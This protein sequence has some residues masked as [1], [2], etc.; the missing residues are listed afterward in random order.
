MAILI[1]VSPTAPPF[2]LGWPESQ[3]STASPAAPTKLAAHTTT[4]LR[5]TWRV[6]TQP[7]AHAIASRLLPVKSSAP[8][9]VT[10]IRPSENARPP[11]Q[12]R[13]GEAERRVA[14]DQREHQR[15]QA[16]ECS[17]EHAEQGHREQ[18]H[19]RL[20]DAEIVD[21]S[22]DLLGGIGVKSV[23]FG[24][25]RAGEVRRL[26]V[27]RKPGRAAVPLA[28]PGERD[29][30]R[31]TGGCQPRSRSRPPRRAV[32]RQAPGHTRS[33]PRRKIG[34]TLSVLANPGSSAKHQ[35]WTHI[36]TA[37]GAFC[38]LDQRSCT[39]RRGRAGP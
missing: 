23:E 15:A 25:S 18:R 38:D 7:S 8:A 12:A 30:P 1:A 5:A 36:A 29:E 37:A 20:D 16:D 19:P 2:R 6:L 9:T 17:G 34:G 24:H 31:G 28:G 39:R 35:E 32:P 10:R 21:P 11:T 13:R 22:R 4:Q 3:T 14:R 26:Y 33:S 27:C